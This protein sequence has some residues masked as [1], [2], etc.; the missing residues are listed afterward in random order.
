[1][2]GSLVVTVDDPAPAAHDGAEVIEASATLEP[3]LRGIDRIW[4]RTAAGDILAPGRVA[5]AALVAVTQPAMAAG[6]DVELRGGAVSAGLLG[7]LDEVQA[8]WSQWRGWAPVRLEAEEAPVGPRP[9]RAAVSAYSGG[10]DS[11][12]TLWRHVDGAAGHQRRRVDA[13]ILVEGFDIPL[14]DPAFSA[15]VRRVAPPV[16][17]R[18]VPVV[19]AA[20][21]VRAIDDDWQAYHGFALASMLTFAGGA[22]GAGLVAST[23]TYARPVIGWGSNAITDPLLGSDAFAIVHDGC[24]AHRVAKVAALAAWPDLL[25]AL[26]F[27]WMG[28]RFDRNCGRCLKCVTMAMILRV[29]DLPT[30]CFDVAPS[31]EVICS[32]LRGAE[33]HGFTAT[34]NQPI[35]DLAVERDRRDP[36]VPVLRNRLR[37]ARLGPAL[38]TLVAP[39]RRRVPPLRRPVGGGS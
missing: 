12:Y 19:T 5:D 28:P 34:Y 37:R 16:A 3:P 4:W 22:Q 6:L 32:V 1:M 33:T 30:T 14:D 35:L 7:N 8:A 24:G 26:R 13:A 18:G 25:A 20:T 39:V 23:D 29:L 2:A 15:A 9:E 38:D 36:W 31:D 10:V 17:D 21:N 11:A 27:C